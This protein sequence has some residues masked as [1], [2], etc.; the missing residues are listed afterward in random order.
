M[1]VCAPEWSFFALE[2]GARSRR[3]KKVNMA[4]IKDVKKCERSTALTTRLKKKIEELE[5]KV[6]MLDLEKKA[7]L[8]ENTRLAGI[9]WQLED[10]IAELQKE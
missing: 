2:F 4:T 5:K 8:E 3:K 1:R 10:D 7:A 6:K 9:N